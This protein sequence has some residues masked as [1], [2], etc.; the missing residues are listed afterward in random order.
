[1]QGQEFHLL[2]RLELQE[3]NSS[4]NRTQAMRTIQGNCKATTVVSTTTW[5]G[6]RPTPSTIIIGSTAHMF[7]KR[8]YSFTDMMFS[9]RDRDSSRDK[10][11]NKCQTTVMK[12]SKR[13]MAPSRKY[14]QLLCS[15]KYTTHLKDMA[16]LE[17]CCFCWWFTRLAYCPCNWRNYGDTTSQP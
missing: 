12:R 5:L 7:G 9:T 8:V 15:I 16:G 6:W 17:C 4:K 11:P 13:K 10:K 14:Q 1:M 3:K 2:Q